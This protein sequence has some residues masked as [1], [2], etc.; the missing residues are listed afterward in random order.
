MPTYRIACGLVSDLPPVRFVP[1]AVEAATAAAAA[2]F[3]H[4]LG[5]EEA[6]LLGDAGDD[7]DAAAAADEEPTNHRPCSLKLSCLMQ[8]TV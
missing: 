7:D 8:V 6:D 2:A 5:Q 3:G 1:E 4:L